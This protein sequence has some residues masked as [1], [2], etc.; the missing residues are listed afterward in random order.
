[1]DSA[2]LSAIQVELSPT[3]QAVMSVSLVVMMFAVALGLRVQDFRALGDEPVPVI[4]G[5]IG[6]LLGLPLLTLGLV[7]LLRPDPSVALGMFVVAACP[8]GNVSNALTLFARGDTAFSVSLTAISS[9]VSAIL[10]PVTILLLANIYTPTAELIDTLDIGPLPFLVQTF[11]L[12]GL[13]L[14]AGMTVA[15]QVPGIAQRLRKVMQP[16]A[17]VILIGLILVGGYSNRDVLFGS[18]AGLFPIVGL[19]NAAAFALGTATAFLLRL[20]TARVRALTFEVGIQNAGLG[21]LILLGQFGGSG[22]AVAVTALWGVWHI[23]AGFAL[24]GLLRGWDYVQA[25]RA[26]TA[27]D[28]EV[29]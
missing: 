7:M 9:V 28:G 15:E 21:L 17:L 5:A 26:E 12:L 1:M 19:H 22:G 11:L 25:R 27:R 14:A 29:L 2:A 3:F 10:T 18:G 16:I 13:P 6:Q 4:G 20:S 8:G 24:V 23:A